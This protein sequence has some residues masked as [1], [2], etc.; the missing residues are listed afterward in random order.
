MPKQKQNEENK[1]DGP[2]DGISPEDIPDE[3]WKAWEA[4]DELWDLQETAE[5]DELCERLQGKG[6]DYAL[7]KED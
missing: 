2:L 5:Y 3:V 4:H 7:A 1:S 6:G